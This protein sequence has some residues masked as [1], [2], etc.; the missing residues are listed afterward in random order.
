MVD[1][2]MAISQLLRFRQP[3]PTFN[4]IACSLMAKPSKTHSPEF[5]T[6]QKLLKY[7]TGHAARDGNHGA[8]GEHVT[9]LASTQITAR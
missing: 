5:L 6:L 4:T 9:I 2:A 3:L 1:S 8:S 7:V